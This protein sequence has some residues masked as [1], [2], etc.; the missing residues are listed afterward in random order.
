MALASALE[1]CCV[2]V[3]ML[4]GGKTHTA[5]QGQSQARV[6]CAARSRQDSAEWVSEQ[7]AHSIQCSI[8]AG[9]NIDVKASTSAHVLRHCLTRRS[10]GGAV[11]LGREALDQ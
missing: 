4:N 10:G 5:L 11:I 3:H 2:Q 6:G 8:T 9:L 7:R 1:V